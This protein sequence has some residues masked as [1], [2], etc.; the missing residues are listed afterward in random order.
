MRTTLV[1]II[2]IVYKTNDGWRGFC[3]P[4]DVTCNAETQALAKERLDNLVALYEDGLK[5]YKNPKHLIIKKLSDE[6]DRN[7]FN[8]FWPKILEDIH[9]KRVSS[10]KE[11][12]SQPVDIERKIPIRGYPF[13]GYSQRP[14]SM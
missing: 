13:I 1:P 5:K 6:E 12:I 8:K 9:K 4:Y 11:Y 2:M 14:L 3:H 7:M 10:Y